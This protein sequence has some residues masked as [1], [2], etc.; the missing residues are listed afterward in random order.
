MSGYLSR[1]V[2]TAVRSSGQLRPLAGSVFDPPTEP[3]RAFPTTLNDAPVVIDFQ[4]PALPSPSTTN[5][6]TAPGNPSPESYLHNYQRLQPRLQESL[7]PIDSQV[8]SPRYPQIAGIHP[9]GTSGENFTTPQKAESRK[10]SLTP[11]SKIKRRS[12]QDSEQST[13]NSERFDRPVAESLTGQRNTAHPTATT[14]SSASSQSQKNV[15]QPLVPAQR[16]ATQPAVTARFQQPFIRN[17]HNQ[18]APEPSV[19]IHI[20]RI[21]VL[22][23]QPPAPPAP[24]PRRDRTTSLTEYLAG[25]NGRRS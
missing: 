14:P 19:E 4:V 16:A 25:R 10:N 9:T 17:Q 24:T 12:D 3:I 18:R 13:L 2:Q 6:S 21:E 23:V 5:Q 7:A 1:I 11:A 22:A 20:G 15:P 8:T